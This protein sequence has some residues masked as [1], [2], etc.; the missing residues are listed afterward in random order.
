MNDFFRDKQQNSHAMFATFSKDSEQFI[1]RF[2][3]VVLFDIIFAL[4]RNI[5]IIFFRGY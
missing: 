2:S 3:V 1:K 5:W 4:R